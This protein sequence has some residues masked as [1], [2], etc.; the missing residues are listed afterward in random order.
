M[1][2]TLQIALLLLLGGQQLFGWGDTGHMLVSQIALSNLT[3]AVRA[4]AEALI[5]VQTGPPSVNVPFHD[6]PFEVASRSASFVTAAC[7]ADDIKSN[8]DREWHYVDMPFSTDGTIP[9]INPP[10][11]NVVNVIEHFTKVLKSPNASQTEQARALRYLLHLVGDLHQPL[12]CATRC[13]HENPDGDRGGNEFQVRGEK[14]LHSFW[15][16]GLRQFER[17]DR[18]LTGAGE[19]RLKTMAQGI[20]KEFPRSALA[21]ELQ[22]QSVMSWAKE[23]HALAKSLAYNLEENERPPNSYLKKAK[24]AARKR[25]AL[26]GY[27]LANL[28]NDALK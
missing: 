18:P 13:T 26:A 19:A 10:A 22:K 23:S 24:P 20:I 21:A 2:K 16:G 28:L 25:V 3:P 6:E 5:R 11:S 15:D 9:R 17:L 14:N 8:L 4:K 1:K 12:H 27:R 7:W